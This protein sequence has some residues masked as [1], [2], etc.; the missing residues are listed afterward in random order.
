MK[1]H[2]SLHESAKRLAR[3][4]LVTEGEL[5]KVLVEML[6]NGSV[7]VLGYKNTFD[8]VQRGLKLSEAQSYYFSK[9]AQKSIEV[10][11]LQHAITSGELSLSQARRIVPV[12]TPQNVSQWV[13]KAASL[14]QRALEF[15]VKKHHPE[16]EVR[17]R[18]RPVADQR[19]ELKCGIS[20]S[21]EKELSHIRD[22]VSQMKRA[23]ASIEDAL[24][25][26]KEAFLEKHDPVRKAQRAAA[27]SSKSQAGL[28][29]AGLPDNCKESQTD[30]RELSNRPTRLSTIAMSAGKRTTLPAAVKHS[31]NLREQAKCTYR[32]SGGTLCGQRRWVHL[33]HLVEVS[34]GGRH[35]SDNL[36]TLCAAH[37]RLVHAESRAG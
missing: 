16:P 33:H 32:G 28:G 9:V 34:R 37:H 23:P 26:M 3:E 20:A 21:L 14:P 2:Q 30:T 25:Y 27:R 36:M 1:S 6:K 17:E 12:V 35:S 7:L 13:E 29:K 18:I 4:Y 10:P 8:Y 22:L 15:E 5:L 24:E 31:V 19:L 11:Q